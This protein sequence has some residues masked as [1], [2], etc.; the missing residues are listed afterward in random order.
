MRASEF[1]TETTTS[2]SIATGAVGTIPAITRNASIYSD[3]SSA[4]KKK[5]KVKSKKY[6]NSKE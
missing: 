5:K 1:I 3:D 4:G 2:G 6:A